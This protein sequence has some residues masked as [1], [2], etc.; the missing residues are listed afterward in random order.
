[1]FNQGSAC[2]E[3]KSPCVAVSL[4]TLLTKDSF[5]SPRGIKLSVKRNIQTAG[6]LQYTA[7]TTY[8]HLQGTKWWY[9]WN[10][11]RSGCCFVMSSGFKKAESLL[12]YKGDDSVQQL[13]S[14]A[15][16]C[17]TQTEIRFFCLFVWGKDEMVSKLLGCEEICRKDFFMS[18]L[19]V[20]GSY[21]IYCGIY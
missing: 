8:R 9:C 1:M 20:H 15:N 10:M 17:S 3:Y 16:L 2:L 5:C 18:K 4:L 7:E 12:F 21:R 6:A 14:E 11:N 19:T 13:N